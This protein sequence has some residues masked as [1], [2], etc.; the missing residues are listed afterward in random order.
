MYRDKKIE[1]SMKH[2]LWKWCTKPN[3]SFWI[4]QLYSLIYAG[5]VNNNF[6]SIQVKDNNNNEN[7]DRFKAFCLRGYAAL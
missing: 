5:K 6:R 2:L 7:N 4:G 3:W 1:R